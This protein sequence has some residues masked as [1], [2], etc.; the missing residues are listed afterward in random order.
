MPN[1]TVGLPATLGELLA[2]TVTAHGDRPAVIDSRRTFTWRE[3]GSLAEGFA[4]QLHVSG[5]RHGDRVAVWLPNSA[6]YLA[7]IFAVAR[8][9]PVVVHL[10]SRFRAHEVG[11]VVRR[12]TPL[13]TGDR[14]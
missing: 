6:G 8:L 7:L 4:S 1:A 11:S 2:R 14:A 3:A 9:G 13:R 5:I 10:N 12:A